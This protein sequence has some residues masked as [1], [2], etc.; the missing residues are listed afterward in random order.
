MKEPRIEKLVISASWYPI[1]VGAEWLIIPF[2]TFP[3]VNLEID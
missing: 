1:I 3:L 2:Q